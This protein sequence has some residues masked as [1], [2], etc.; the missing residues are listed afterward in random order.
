MSALTIGQTRLGLQLTPVLSGEWVE[1]VRPASNY[2]YENQEGSA[3][4]EIKREVIKPTLQLFHGLVEMTPIEAHDSFFARPEANGTLTLIK[5]RVPLWHISHVRLILGKNENGSLL[6]QPYPDLLLSPEK[7]E[8]LL[9][10]I[11]PPEDYELP[12]VMV[13]DAIYSL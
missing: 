4:P 8:F 12:S 13:D 9:S 7:Q 1:I 2:T 3:F 11:A 6:E 5:E 10:P